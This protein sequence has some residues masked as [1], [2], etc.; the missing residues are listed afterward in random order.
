MALAAHRH[1]LAPFE[2]SFSFVLN[3]G[4]RQYKKPLSHPWPSGSGATFQSLR[5]LHREGI[6]VCSS[7]T[8][9]YSVARQIAMSLWMR[10]WPSGTM[11]MITTCFD[12]SGS[13]DTGRFRFV[14]RKQE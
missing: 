12:G 8:D 13:P 1:H 10:N 3:G 4:A 11:A 5:T 14:L 6:A 7:H 9:Q 2:L